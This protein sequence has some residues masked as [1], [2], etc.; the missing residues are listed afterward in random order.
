MA[1]LLRPYMSNEYVKENK[2]KGS[3]GDCVSVQYNIGVQAN[4]APSDHVLS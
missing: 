2:K 4:L 3:G 1:P